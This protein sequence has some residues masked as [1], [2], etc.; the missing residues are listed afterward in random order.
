M[1]KIS[2]LEKI[3]DYIRKRAREKFPSN[4]KFAKAARIHEASIR[5]FYA[6]DQNPTIIMLEKMCDALDIKMS[7]MLKELGK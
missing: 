4:V 3:V 1:A 2:L 7:D 6:G 5:R